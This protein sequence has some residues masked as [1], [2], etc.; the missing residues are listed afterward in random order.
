MASGNLLI[1]KKDGV[2]LLTINRPTVMNSLDNAVLDELQGA[3]ENLGEDKSVRVIVLT[4]AG[5]KAFVAGADIS[6]MS[7]FTVAQALAFARKGD[8]LV[9]FIGRLSKPVIGA[10]NGFALG[11]GLEMA[12]A[13]DFV[14]ASEKAR[15]GLPEVSLGVMPGFGGTQKL[16]RL[17]GR[18]RANEMIFTG[19]LL[20]AEEAKACGLVNAVFPA[21]ELLERTMETARRIAGQGLIGV[22]YAKESVRSGLDMGEAEGMDH[23]ALLFAALFATADQREG[24]RAFIEKR[25]PVFTGN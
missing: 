20:T 13:C 7:E 17:V 19:N 22:A 24:M 14:Y 23:E 3:F 18:S 15:L 5:E 11:G 6:A 25:K 10:V 16:A 21:A 12:M 1:E 8:K 4:G 9:N 2:A